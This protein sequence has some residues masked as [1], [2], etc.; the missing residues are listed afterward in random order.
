[1]LRMHS[2][3]S[4]YEVYLHLLPQDYEPE[5]LCRFRYSDSDNKQA[6]YHAWRHLTSNEE[7]TDAKAEMLLQLC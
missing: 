1:M 3:Y 2:T 4:S 5:Q 7:E 6:E